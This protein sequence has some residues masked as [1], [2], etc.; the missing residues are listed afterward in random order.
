[1]KIFKSKFATLPGTNYP[2]V[3]KKAFALYKKIKSRSKRRPYIRSAYFGNNKI[4]LGLFW[5]HLNQKNWHDRFRRVKYFPCA[6]DLIKNSKFAPSSKQNPN[7]PNELLHR[8]N[9]LTKNNDP[10]TV[11]IKEDKSTDQKWFLSVFPANQ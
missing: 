8:F 11:Q 7:K 9:G 10:F 3:Y 5:D 2:E 4:F 6:I 1:M